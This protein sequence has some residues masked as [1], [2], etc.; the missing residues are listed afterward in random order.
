MC[1]SI[2]NLNLLGKFLRLYIEESFIFSYEETEA[3]QEKLKQ[4]N[5]NIFEILLLFF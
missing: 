4:T 3:M 5:S 2:A 1:A